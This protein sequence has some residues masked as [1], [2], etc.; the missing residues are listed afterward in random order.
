MIQSDLTV[1]QKQRLEAVQ[2][3]LQ[4][5]QQQLTKIQQEVSAVERIKPEKEETTLL[6]QKVDR[7]ATR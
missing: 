2:S 7:W 5:V 3:D 1:E 4:Q 6:R